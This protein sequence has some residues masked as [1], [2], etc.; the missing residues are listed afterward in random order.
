MKST[1]IFVI[2]KKE[3]E[4]GPKLKFCNKK[5]FYRNPNEQKSLIFNE[6][7]NYKITTLF[8]CSVWI[9]ELKKQ[10]E[11][12]PLLTFFVSAERNAGSK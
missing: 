9:P 2:Q 1:A 7:I 4:A 5:N 10:K 6:G 12:L 3:F 8:H 11:R